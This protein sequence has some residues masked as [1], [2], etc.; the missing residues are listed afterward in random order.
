MPGSMRVTVGD[1][2]EQ[3][4]VGRARQHFVSRGELILS[5]QSQEFVDLPRRCL[6]FLFSCLDHKTHFLF[7]SFAFWENR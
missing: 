1:R 4:A 3:W 2:Y 7:F 5:H 6:A